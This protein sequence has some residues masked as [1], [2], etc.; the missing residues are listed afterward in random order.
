MRLLGVLGAVLFAVAGIL[1]IETWSKKEYDENNT[2]F[3]FCG[4]VLLTVGIIS[5]INAVLLCV[6]TIYCYRVW[7]K[8]LCR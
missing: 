4:K 5:I 3:K 7:V 8:A 1:S 6:D 2:E